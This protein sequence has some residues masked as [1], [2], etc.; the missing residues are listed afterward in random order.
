MRRASRLRWPHRRSLVDD[1]DSV[2]RGRPNC[3]RHELFAKLR[4]GKPILYSPTLKAWVVS[5]YDDARSVLERHE[6]GHVKHGPGMIIL[7]GG[8]S[9]WSGREHS[10]K[11]G[12][13]ARRLGGARA[14]RDHIAAGIAAIAAELANR[15]PLEEEIDLKEA[16]AAQVP[17]L[18]ICKLMAIDEPAWLRTWYST[19]MTNACQTA[20][21][22]IP[23][24]VAE[25]IGEL[26]RLIAPALAERRGRPSADLVSDLAN[27]TFDGELLPDDEI[28]MVVA[29]LFAAMMETT[30]RMLTFA[31]RHL[32]LNADLIDALR[33]R[34][35]DDD[36]LAAFGAEALRLY[37]PIQAIARMAVEPACIAGRDVG[38]GETVFA[39]LASANRDERRFADPHRFDPER[40]LPN[41]GRQFTAAGDILSFGAGEHRCTGSR[42]AELTVV[43]ALRQL[44]GRV[45]R[46]DA[47][48]E[49][50]DT[51]GLIFWSPQS[52]PVVLHGAE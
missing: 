34:R 10:K 11:M 2:A 33:E 37:S 18:V 44:L 51:G 38:E 29:Q 46:I 43:E 31:L 41:P 47:V 25:S 21:D 32:S 36:P 5:R 28:V 6:F 42:L 26:E 40:F 9:D 13:V 4:K 22:A 27:A 49:A 14:M 20:Y 16:Y 30:E 3:D 48:E 39:L 1:F 50:V 23:A 12:I 15:L 17:P 52:L 35:D 24:V 45:D 19:L 8:F 7:Q